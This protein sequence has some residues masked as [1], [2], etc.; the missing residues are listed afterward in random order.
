MLQNTI[1]GIGRLCADQRGQ[2]F[3]EYALIAGL[4]AASAVTDIVGRTLKRSFRQG[5][6]CPRQSHCVT[7]SVSLL[8]VQFCQERFPSGP[9]RTAFLPCP[10]VL[11]AC[12]LLPACHRH[13]DRD[14][15]RRVLR[16]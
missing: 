2:D 3:I 13:H 12:L 15:P 9:A 14:E 4:V 11:A 1:K 10:T 5:Y 6:G 8:E 7:F 16:P